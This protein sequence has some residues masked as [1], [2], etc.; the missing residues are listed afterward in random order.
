M[1]EGSPSFFVLVFVS[2]RRFNGQLI[3]KPSESVIYPSRYQP[4][5]A[6][7]TGINNA[8]V[9]MYSIDLLL[10]RHWITV[11]CVLCRL[12]SWESPSNKEIKKD[13]FTR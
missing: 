4:F 11:L 8:Q 7:C 3:I 1:I 9:R 12:V 2:I 10:R 5:V 6:S 13:H